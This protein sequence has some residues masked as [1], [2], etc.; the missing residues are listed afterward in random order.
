MTTPTYAHSPSN[1]GGQGSKRNKKNALLGPKR[2][3]PEYSSGGGEDGSAGGGGGDDRSSFSEDEVA[4][5][6][7]FQPQVLVSDVGS[8]KYGKASQQPQQH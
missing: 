3:R 4:N 5:R 1:P 6:P 2:F 8:A 7:E